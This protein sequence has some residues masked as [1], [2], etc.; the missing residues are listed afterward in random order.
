M[1][2]RAYAKG[3]ESPP[4][5]RACRDG[6]CHEEAQIRQLQIQVR[7]ITKER[8]SVG[9]LIWRCHMPGAIRNF[10][11]NRDAKRYVD[12]IEVDLVRR[13]KLQQ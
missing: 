1:D 2:A 4:A 5:A 8:L 11:S 7:L 3:A 10:L 12:D 6:S 13:A 9:K